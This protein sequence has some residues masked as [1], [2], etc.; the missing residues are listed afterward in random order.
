MPTYVAQR[1]LRIGSKVYERGERLTSKVVESLPE[2]TRKALERLG[3]ISETAEE[4]K[5]EDS[6]RKAGG[7]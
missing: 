3:W 7:P 1:E 4:A 2:R 6:R 5:R